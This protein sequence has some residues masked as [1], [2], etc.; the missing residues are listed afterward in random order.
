MVN[1]YALSCAFF[2]LQISVSSLRFSNHPRRY[3]PSRYNF[4]RSQSRINNIDS[5]SQFL[6]VSNPQ[7]THTQVENKSDY[8]KL[9]NPSPSSPYIYVEMYNLTDI[10]LQNETDR[11]DAYKK[12]FSFLQ[13]RREKKVD[14]SQNFEVIK[15]DGFTFDDV[16]GYNQIKEEMLQCAD[17][18]INFEKYQ[19]YNIRTPKGIILEGPPGNGKTMLARGFSGSI[20][21]S[22]IQTTGSS[23]QEKYVGVGSSRVRELFKLASTNKPCVIFIDEIDAIGRKR[24]SGGDESSH[25]ERDNTLNQLLT[26]LDG[27]KSSNGV[28]MVCATN[29][30]DL[31]DKALLRPG[32]IDK[33]IYIGNPDAKTR[34]EIISIHLAGK[35]YEPKISVP[36]LVEKTN[37]MSG[38]QIENVLNEAML[39]ALR[40]ND[41]FM[42]KSHIEQVITR[43][44]TGYQENANIY[45]DDVIRRIAIHELGHA[46]AGILQK[47]HAR[48]VSVNLNLKSPKSPGYTVFEHD[49]IDANIYTKEKLF[50]HLVVLLSG[51]TAEDV[52]FDHSVTSGASHDFEQAKQLAYNM[53]INYN[54]GAQNIYSSNSDKFKEII[55][56]EVKMLIDDAILHSKRIIHQ[57][58]NLISELTPELILNHTISRDALKSKI[59]EEYQHLAR[60]KF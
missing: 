47:D 43:M 36:Y 60:M 21:A 27:F 49:E 9:V 16:G 29:R 41:V 40:S 4:R 11:R 33:S 23:F 14:S 24:G 46:I 35:A 51:R 39:L 59:C 53:V 55:D 42:R 32:R 34:E 25:A 50:A 45:S 12:I 38:A 20:N 2:T 1:F 3:H 13:E 31:L 28:F 22:F 26:E 18:L 7:Q 6:N 57:S 17:T 56:I 30:I 10:K 44:L 48:V 19:K 58:K 8:W 52:F 54:M 15:N 5:Y 37:G